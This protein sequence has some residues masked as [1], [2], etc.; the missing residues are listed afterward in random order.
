[1]NDTIV[2]IRQPYKGRW[3]VTEFGSLIGTVIG[4]AVIGFTARDACQHTLG[5]SKFETAE[6][7]L[8]CVLLSQA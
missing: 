6:E 8:D 2:E 5:V 4:D 3:E 1:M 7:A